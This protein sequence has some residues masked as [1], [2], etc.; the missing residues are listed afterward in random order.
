MSESV[1]IPEEPRP[2]EPHA[3]EKRQSPPPP[4]AGPDRELRPF[5]ATHERPPLPD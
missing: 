4:P 2:I 1:H 5:S 3:P